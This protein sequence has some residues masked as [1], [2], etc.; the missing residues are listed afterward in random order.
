M[1]TKENL[2]PEEILA[3]IKPVEWKWKDPQQV[4]AEKPQDLNRLLESLSDCV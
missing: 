3:S 4:E 2:S 1:E